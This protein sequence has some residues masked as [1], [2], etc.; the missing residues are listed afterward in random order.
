[1]GQL[2]VAPAQANRPWAL[3]RPNGFSKLWAS[4]APMP[5]LETLKF[6]TLNS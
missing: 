1:M 4:P 6:W 5:S 2:A 3:E